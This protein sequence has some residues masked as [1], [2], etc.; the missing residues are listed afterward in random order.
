MIRF[1]QPKTF[2]QSSF[3]YYLQ[4]AIETNHFSNYGWAVKLLEER[5]RELLK[6]EDS[7]AVIATSSGTAALAAMV[8]G[9]RRHTKNKKRRVCTQ[10]FTFPTNSLGPAEGP[11]VADLNTTCMI[12]F[13]EKHINESGDIIVLTNC[14]GHLYDIKLAEEKL[15]NKIIIY[16]N[17]ASPYSFFEGRNSCNYGV[18][19]F[20]SLHHTKP[21]GFGEGGL[22]IIDREY[23]KYTRAAVNFGM[24]EGVFNEHGGNHKMSELSAAGILQWWDQFDIDELASKY[25]DNYFKTRYEMRTYQGDFWPNHS[26]DKFFPNCLPF[27]H[28][29]PTEITEL[30]GK[31]VKKYYRP[32][33]GFPVSNFIYDRISCVSLTEGL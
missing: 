6:I 3:N 21:I 1:I 27:I 22:A 17:A 16:D 5:A 4:H 13:D 2:S 11:I 9:I 19:S 15:G 25:V 26:D 18:G 12:D 29:E 24:I 33:R 14:F 23:E 32:L 7:K 31:E 20:I 10:D 30:N 8:Q 28:K